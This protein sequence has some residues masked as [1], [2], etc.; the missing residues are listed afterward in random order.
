MR[1]RTVYSTIGFPGLKAG[2]V[3]PSGGRFVAFDN[4]AGACLVE[5]FRFRATAVK[6]IRGEIEIEQRHK[7]E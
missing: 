5:E 3:Y 2:G 7:Y 1:K 6:W 4:R